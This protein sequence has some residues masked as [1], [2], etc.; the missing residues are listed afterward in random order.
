MSAYLRVVGQLRNLLGPRSKD[1]AKSKPK[2]DLLCPYCA[3]DTRPWSNPMYRVCSNKDCQEVTKV[4]ECLDEAV[5]EGIKADLHLEILSDKTNPTRAVLAS[6]LKEEFK[7]ELIPKLE[8]TIEQRVR[9]KLASY[10]PSAQDRRA[11]RMYLQ[12]LELD[13]QTRAETVSRQVQALEARRPKSF[14]NIVTLSFAAISTIFALIRT[15]DPM[16]NVELAICIGCVF[17]ITSL[18]GGYRYFA[19]KAK[20]E[21]EIKELHSLSAQYH[22]IADKAKR[23]RMV[24]V[25]TESSLAAL[26]SMTLEYSAT[27]RELDLTMVTTGNEMDAARQYVRTRIAEDP[28][29]EKFEQLEQAQEDQEN[30]LSAESKTQTV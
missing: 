27:K 25:D 10:S 11:F 6:D 20:R 7:A 8:G 17:L 19:V 30:E 5:R 3:E 9:K 21:A 15:T 24:E 22:A 12:D 14:F 23:Y 2:G 18:A 16:F 4:I 13:A 28:L 1:M 29:E 26:K